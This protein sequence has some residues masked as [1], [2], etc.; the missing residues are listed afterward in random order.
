MEIIA[1]KNV[2]LLLAIST[3]C[4][5]SQNI[6]CSLSGSVQDS[7][8]AAFPG[9]ELQLVSEQTGFSRTGK[10]NPDG[11]FSFPDL[12]PSKFTLTIS[13]AGFKRRIE[14]EIEIGSGDQR[15]L[16]V[17]KL[18]VGDVSESVT[19]TAEAAPVQLGSSDRA[20]GLTGEELD[21]LAL[22]GRDFMD[23]VGLL[24]GVVDLSDGREAPGAGSIADIYILGGRSNQKNMTV[25]GITNLDTGSNNS[26][27]SMPSMDS[28]GELKVLMSNYAAE[29]GRNSGGTITVITKG[30]GKQFHGSA[31]WY[32]RHE[33]MTANNFFN[34]RNG[35]ERPPYR[36][37]IFNY[38]LSGP[39]YIPGKLNKD[40]SK[41]FF[42]FSQEIQR[43]KL[44]YGTKTV[45]VPTALERQGDFSQTYDV[46]GK[47]IAV[48]DP[49]VG[50]VAFPGNKVPASR[51]N[52][53]GQAI[54]GLFPMPNFVDPSP[55]RANQWN[56]ISSNTGSYPRHAETGRV[57]Y[58]PRDNVQF[59]VRVANSLDQEHPV[60]DGPFVTGKMNFP[61]TSVD[62]RRPGKSGAVH[63]TVTLSPT[64]F[65]EFTFG[66]S[67]NKLFFSPDFPDRV[68]R[69]KT[70]ILLPSWNPDANRGDLIPNMTFTSVPNY[71]NP[72]MHAGIP[73]YNTNTIFS[74]VDNV[75]KIAG[76]HMLKFGVYVERS[77]KD[78][79]ANALTRGNLSFNRD[80]N[81]PL[82]TNYAY[83]SALMGIYTSYD[84]A[85]SN[86][87]GQYRFTNLEW[88]AQ[89]TWR[90]RPGL[91]L[92]AGLRF[93]RN[94]PQY[95]ARNQLASFNMALYDPKNAPVLLRP[96]FDA[97]GKKVAIDPIS[98]KTFNAGLIGTFVPGVG[99]IANGMAQAGQ[100][101]V[102]ASVYTLPALAFAPRLG[103]S[104]DPF[105][106]GRTAVRGG[107]GV[108]FDRI[109]GNPTMNM[110]NNPP[111]VLDPTVYYGTFDE[112]AA[113]AG[114][115]FLAPNASTSLVGEGKL[116][117][118]YNF[119]F[120]GQH[121][122][123][124]SMILDVAYVGS[125]TRHALWQ[126]NINPIPI[127]ATHIDLH[128]ENI[129]ITT[130]KA[131]AAPFL[132]PIPSFD[133]INLYEF[134]STA[135]YHSLQVGFNRRFARGLQIGGSYTFS[136]VL[137]S[138]QSDTAKVS[139][140]FAPRGFNYGPLNYDR[141]QTASIR[142]SWTLPELGKR[143]QMRT[144]GVLT[145]GWQIS[146]ISRFS[147]GAP[148]TP[149]YAL[150][151]SVDVT[152]TASQTARIV[153]KDPNA[154][155]LN[156]FAAPARGTFGNAGVGILRGP[157]FANL[158]VS[159]YR[160]IRI[161]E[162]KTLQLRFETYNTLNHTQ[163][164]A[165]TQQARFDAA[166][167]QVDPLFL[168]PTA[169]RGARRIQLA[170]RLNF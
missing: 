170:L 154:D 165:V 55:A 77:R 81:S 110:M 152:G 101:G 103:F 102:P 22:R 83:A 116:P 158:D 134:A 76:T 14:S 50:R 32:H 139:P 66:A 59:Y 19:V 73:Y 117:T 47:L 56:Y 156:R 71:A 90:V 119:S 111:I 54:L 95:D 135:N 78:Q 18:L 140:F 6:S 53:I 125:L 129:D 40:R 85:S 3:G 80:N 131:Y 44:D 108:F 92:D 99:S 35:I 39:V 15:S 93:Y 162:R 142:F 72:S 31:S 97:N 58:S 69:T 127:G 2:L 98:G 75:S 151:N 34:N 143:F 84:E 167:N 115:A 51:F 1:V 88:Y 100:N 128:P 65:N 138:A 166:G 82:D 28:I 159:V 20:V 13:A 155:P 126:R 46:N 33:N 29:Y 146:G 24:A 9:A 114:A 37:N 91:T 12:T 23:A 113:Q 161:H 30:G 62:Y 168:E 79:S 7:L 94:Q 52:P 43:Q 106:K 118:V 25:D 63:A 148:F 36:Y 163:F 17:L 41:V 68:S 112:L 67:Q 105:R 133:D 89:D 87:Q 38:T 144:L 27:H 11:F 157:G 107:I 26:V 147:T 45:R 49:L 5:Y 4:A 122:L 132:R 74:F 123:D 42:F 96:A 130:K 104:W 120:G 150:V 145:D 70:G 149:T 124:R 153:V 160:N 169:A 16:G 57:D 164:S 64:L 60:V 86:P 61:L 8:G 136:K 121:Q 21:N 10:T 141:S 48:Y 109:A 137:G